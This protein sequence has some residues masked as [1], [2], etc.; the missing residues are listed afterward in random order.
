MFE[1][2]ERSKSLNNIPPKKVE[3]ILKK[4]DLGSQERISK[5]KKKNLLLKYVE[6]NIPIEYWNL[7][8]ERDFK[9][10]S[11][12]QEKYQQYIQELDNNY[13][14]GKS[15]CLM[16]NYGLGKSLVL[17]NIL[18]NAISKNYSCL[19]TTLSDS[20]SALT[21]SSDRALVRKELMMVDFLVI[22]E[23]DIRFIGSDQAADLYARTLETVLRSRLSNKLPTLLA[24]NSPNPIGAFSGML[25]ESLSSLSNYIEMF[26]VLGNDFRKTNSE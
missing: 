16:G 24:S 1:Q 12:L 23:F 22:D 7:K 4:I 5:I 6:A 8:M 26:A 25:K 10:D 11:R 2:L 13:L 15:I 9:G 18:K 14:K 19:Y 17:T 21:Q 3:I 20:V